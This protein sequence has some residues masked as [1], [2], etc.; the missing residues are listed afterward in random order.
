MNKD[1]A[2]EQ[3]APSNAKKAAKP[4]NREGRDMIKVKL[5]D[6]G[7]YKADGKGNMVEVPKGSVLEFKSEADIPGCIEFKIEILPKGS[8]EKATAKAGDEAPVAGAQTQ[9]EIDAGDRMKIFRIAWSDVP[10]NK[11]GKKGKVSL[12]ALNAVVPPQIPKFTQDEFDAL[13]KKRG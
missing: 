3:A 12:D 8:E 9:D 4:S 13:A 7:Y 6:S 10:D 1:G 11:R 5:I 2:V